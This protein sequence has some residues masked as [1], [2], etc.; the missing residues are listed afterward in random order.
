MRD[1]DGLAQFPAEEATSGCAPG[2]PGRREP[3]LKEPES[4]TAPTAPLK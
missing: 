4:Q 2:L 1:V 3:G